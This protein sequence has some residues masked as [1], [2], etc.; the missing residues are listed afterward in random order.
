MVRRS[1]RGLWIA[2]VLLAGGLL[3][4]AP[5]ED[6]GGRPPPSDAVPAGPDKQASDKQ[7]ET[8]PGRIIRGALT[9]PDRVRRAYLWD[10]ASDRKVPLAVDP[11]T[12]TFEAAGLPLGT[13]DLVIE[14]PWGRLEGIDMEPK[15]SDYD[16]LI[17][18]AYRTGDLGR[19]AQGSLT[20]D[21]RRTIRRLIY[22]VKRYENK[23]RDLVLQGSADRAVV[24]ME[25]MMDADFHGRQGDEITWRLEQWY[26]EKKYDAW[27]TFRTRVLYRFRIA[28]AAWLTWG[29]QFEPRLGGFDI[30]DDRTEPRVVEFVVPGKPVPEKG[31][32]G[33]RLPPVDEGR[34][35]DP[36]PAEE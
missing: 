1:N 8:N 13:Y 33:D 19:P 4:A 21:D 30:T 20:E 28:K 23:I 32:V 26:Y 14:T 5:Q 12:G 15:L 36:P 31:L 29:W 25:L 2:A 24:L 3:A 27:T 11:A 10:R 22:D 17:P 16:A 34:P 35:T 6:T 9:P 18:P 7:A